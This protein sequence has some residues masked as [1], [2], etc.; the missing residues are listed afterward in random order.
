MAHIIEVA[1][2]GRATCRSCR[3]AIA[4]GELRFGEETVNQFSD[5]GEPAYRWHHVLCAAK[6]LPNE[7]TGALKTYEGEV[8][9]REEIEK[10]AAEAAAKKPPPFPYVDRAPTGR[11]KCMEC[12]EAIA[13]DAVRVAVERDIERGMSTVKGAGYMHPACVPAHL[14][15]N[16]LPADE[17]VAGLRENTRV[18]SKEDL[19]AVLAEINEGGG[20]AT[21]PAG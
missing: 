11:A 14:E 9:N 10:A 17:L 1:K 4:K 19:E 3:S 21:E 13:K 7:V 15:A 16:A 2:S 8:P 12:G 18:L 5:S 20:V 6:N